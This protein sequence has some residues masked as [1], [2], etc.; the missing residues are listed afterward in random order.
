M[1]IGSQDVI[2]EIQSQIQGTLKQIFVRRLILTF[3]RRLND[4]W[5][6]KASDLADKSWDNIQNLLMSR[7]E[8][9]L[10]R[11][12]DLLLGKTGEIAQDLDANEDLISK[13]LTDDSALMHALILMTRGRVIT[14]DERTH[15]KKFKGVTRLTYI[16][17]AANMLEDQP[18][19]DI[20]SAILEH[21]EEAQ[22]KLCEVWGQVEL[23]RLHNSG[24]TLSELSNEWHTRFS[25]AMGVDLFSQVGSAP[26]DQLPP[27]AHGQ[28]VTVLGRNVQN[29]LYRQLLLSKISELWVEYLTKVEALR[30]S[31]RMESYGQRDPLVTYRGQA[32]EM[33]S[34]LLSD[35]RAGVIDRMFRA[36]LS[37]PEEMQKAKSQ[38]RQPQAAPTPAQGKKRKKKSR[39]RH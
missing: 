25:E 12:S 2:N 39:K 22:D 33:F 31:V 26:I 34:D 23:L 24:H 30:V 1:K 9:T 3:E 10:E 15:R 37:S 4:N 36:R 27:F 35:I 18:I 5:N 17:L 38:A 14:F 7:F 8:N 20:Q 21:L 16:F 29:N 19:E 13:A 32:S 11:R 6:L 28:V